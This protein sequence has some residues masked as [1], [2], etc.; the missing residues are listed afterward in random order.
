MTTIKRRLET[1]LEQNLFRNYRYADKAVFADLQI[2][3]SK[4]TDDRQLP[5]LEI[6][7]QGV[8]ITEG[9]EGT[10]EGEY[11]GTVTCEVVTSADDGTATESD[12]VVR[13][14]EKLLTSATIKAALN[15][16]TGTDGRPVKNIFIYDANLD[17]SDEEVIERS[18]STI[19]ALSVL[20]RAD[21]G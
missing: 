17:S 5:R 3:T 4:A 15:K 1:A 9:F 2:L 7:T 8:K 20:F 16:P 12:A 6:V 18:R 10:G 11:E 21:N 13:G 19:Y 14:V